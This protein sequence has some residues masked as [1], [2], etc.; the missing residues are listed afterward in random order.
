MKYNKY[1][2]QYVMKSIYYKAVFCKPEY[3]VFWSQIL[4]LRSYV[5]KRIIF[6]QFGV[7]TKL[8]KSHCILGWLN[9]SPWKTEYS[10]FRLLHFPEV[11]DTLLCTTSISRIFYYLVMNK[12]F[13]CFCLIGSYL[14]EH[15]SPLCM[16]IIKRSFWIMSF[17]PQCKTCY[18]SK[19]HGESKS[20]IM[21]DTYKK[22]RWGSMGLKYYK[23]EQEFRSK[24]WWT[25]KE[26]YK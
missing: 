2:F 18:S 10:V 26:D 20:S 24:F 5:V 22:S 12:L 14:N 8:Q 4:V 25:Q 6:I 3:Q 15:P 23:L 21:Y 19:I 16:D 7:V 11:Y 9:L 17:S 1:D 13:K